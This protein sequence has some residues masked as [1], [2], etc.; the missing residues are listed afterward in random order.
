EKDATEKG[1]AEIKSIFGGRFIT[2][3]VKIPFGQFKFEWHGIYGYDRVKKQYT[4]VWID[5]H[6]TTTEAGIGEADK[7][8]CVI[9]FRGEHHDPHVGGMA[10]F[11]W[12]I[13]NDGKDALTIEMFEV[14]KDGK[15]TL[16]MKVK[17]KKIK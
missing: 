13:A 8:G 11:A 1:M 10:K 15:E 17:G 6:D 16:A 12:R 7:T 9:T 14:A 3:D 5:N 2:E 4:A